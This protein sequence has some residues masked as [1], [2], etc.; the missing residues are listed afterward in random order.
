MVNHKK[1]KFNIVQRLFCNLPSL[2][3]LHAVGVFYKALRTA[4]IMFR[5]S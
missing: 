2:C 3:A 5:F 4:T 1:T